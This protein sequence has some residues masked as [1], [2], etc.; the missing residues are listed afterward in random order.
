ME[1][2]LEMVKREWQEFHLHSRREGFFQ[3]EMEENEL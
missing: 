1:T 2:D 3:R